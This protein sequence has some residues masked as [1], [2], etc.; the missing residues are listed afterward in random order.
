MTEL[1]FGVSVVGGV[2]EV[3]D[4][5]EDD[6]GGVI[7]RGC[8]AW[9]TGELEVGGSGGCEQLDS[10]AVSIA[11]TNHR[12]R[13]LVHR[14]EKGRRVVGVVCMVGT[15]LGASVVSV[16]FT[17]LTTPGRRRSEIDVVTGRYRRWAG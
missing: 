16:R 4:A 12:A 15:S 13:C 2:V 3:P 11:A 6:S 10:R 17:G 1:P 9:G 5:R 14:L 8:D 7:H